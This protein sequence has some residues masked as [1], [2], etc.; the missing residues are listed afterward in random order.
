M[1]RI[2]SIIRSICLV[3]LM[4]SSIVACKFNTEKEVHIEGAAYQCPMKCEGDSTHATQENCSVCGMK[5][6]AVQN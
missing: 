1:K 2:N 3:L 6:Q 4:S 5:T